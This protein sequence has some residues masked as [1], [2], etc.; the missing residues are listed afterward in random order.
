M[1]PREGMSNSMFVRSPWLSMLV[2][3]PLRRVTMSIIFEANSSG[4]LMVSSSMGSHF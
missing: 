2:I 1:M 3:S 4:T